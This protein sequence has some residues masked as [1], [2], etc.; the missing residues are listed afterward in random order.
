MAAG[1]KP[2][3]RLT[4]TDENVDAVLSPV[5]GSPL[6]TI[7]T[8]AGSILGGAAGGAVGA[9]LGAVGDNLLFELL[10]ETPAVVQEDA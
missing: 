8:L 7:G 9:T 2:R 4:T 6:S 1:R 3:P 10:G 5:L